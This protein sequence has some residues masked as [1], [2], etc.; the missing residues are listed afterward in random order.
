MYK[1][2]FAKY[3]YLYGVHTINQATKKKG[4]KLNKSN[5][6]FLISNRLDNQ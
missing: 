3:E 2:I 1:F 5:N 4:N 6:I